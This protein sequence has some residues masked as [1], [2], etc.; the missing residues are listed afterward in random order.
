MITNIIITFC[1][2]GNLFSAERDTGHLTIYYIEQGKF[3]SIHTKDFSD[4]ADWSAVQQLSHTLYDQTLAALTLNP[5]ISVDQVTPKMLTPDERHGIGTRRL[6]LQSEEINEA[7][8]QLEGVLKKYDLRDGRRQA[9]DVQKIRTQPHAWRLTPFINPR[10]DGSVCIAFD[11]QRDKLEGFL[12]DTLKDRQKR[13][14]DLT[15]QE[16]RMSL[17]EVKRYIGSN[18]S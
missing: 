12:S 1:L 9:E 8:A 15:H 6:L 14:L 16:G 2:L 5:D 17:L 18:N 13:G 3:R 4:S 11:G 7:L 10:G